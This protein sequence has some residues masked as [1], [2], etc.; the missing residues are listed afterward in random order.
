[1]WSR[2]KVHDYFHLISLFLIIL[3]FDHIKLTQN[4]F[5]ADTEFVIVF[6][7]VIYHPLI[8]EMGNSEITFLLFA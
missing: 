4:Q 2:V 5:A 7:L 6:F 8:M 1:M 3:L